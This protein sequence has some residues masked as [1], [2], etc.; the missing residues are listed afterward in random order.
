MNKS[1]TIIAIVFVALIASGAAYVV[2]TEYSST[3]DAP[4][5][6]E[7]P[8]QP[9]AQT[10]P[11]PTDS[12]KNP[13]STTGTDT[14]SETK[15]SSDSSTD[16]TNNN[17]N[18]N[19]NQ[20]KPVTIVDDGNTTVTINSVPKRIVS[21]APSITEILFAAGA[22]DQVIGVTDYCNYP[23]NFKD[24]ITAGNMTSIGGYWQP[25]IEPI[26]AL[27]PDLV[28]AAGDGA[29]N[30]AAAKLRALDYT[31]IV[32]NPQS[33]KDILNALDIIGKAT[34]N[35]AKATQ[36]INAIQTRI[37]AV[38]AKVAGVTDKP[39]VCY[40]MG[41]TYAAGSGSFIGDLI[42]LA[43]GVNVFG[44]LVAAYPQVSREIV[45]A[46]NPDIIITS[47]APS[48]FLNNANWATINAVVNGRVYQ[49]SVYDAYARNGP[50]FID[51]LEEIATMI[52]PELFGA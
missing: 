31:V 35:D 23:Y 22:G 49:G 1:I 34:G 18:N 37:D 30:E 28:I 13:A 24:W 3:P 39:N 21:L 45:L 16:T 25:A 33:V 15:K 8:T 27:N 2:Y 17:S 9:S 19:N 41:T 29:S 42:T 26:M 36:T 43:G 44:D 14:N 47:S 50:R 48:T 6:P 12:A 52:H 46:K 20:P 11:S 7:V 38:T 51:V 10:Q 4:L 40:M 5:N 32:L